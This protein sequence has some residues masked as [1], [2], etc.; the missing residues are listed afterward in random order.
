MRVSCDTCGRVLLIDRS[1]LGRWIRCP[2]CHSLIEVIAPRI[3]EEAAAYTCFTII[4]VVSGVTIFWMSVS[5]IAGVIFGVTFITFA[6]LAVCL[7]SIRHRRE[8]DEFLFRPLEVDSEST[9][10]L[11]RFLDAAGDHAVTSLALFDVLYNLG[12]VDPM[13]LRGVDHLHHGQEFS[14]LNDVSIFL[15]E[16][17]IG[18]DFTV[19]HWERLIHKYK[20]YTGEQYLFDLWRREGIDVEVPES[21]THA[22][23]DATVDGESVNVKVT[24]NPAY[25]RQAL[26]EHPDVTIVTNLEMASHFPDHP[27]VTVKPEMSEH[28]IY[29]RTEASLEGIDD[30]GNLFDNL[31]VLIL[32]AASLRNAKSVQE[33][34]K[35]LLDAAKHIAV[36]TTA[37]GGGGLVGAHLGLM[38][39]TLLTPVTGGASLLIV[40]GTT[41]GGVLSGKLGGRKVAQ[42]VKERRLR[43]L[44]KDLELVSALLFE[45]F[46][47]NHTRLVAVATGP[48]KKLSDELNRHDRLHQGWCGRTFFPSAFTRF[49]YKANLRLRSEIAGQEGYY[50]GLL[51]QPGDQATPG[52]RGMYVFAQG[53]QILLGHPRL[54]EAYRATESLVVDVGKERDRVS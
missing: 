11:N 42:W 19:S 44:L 48:A 31:P 14:N 16:H 33:G 5:A 34:K 39:G 53:E 47:K 49:I 21:G 30:L 40:P 17:I 29:D 10:R 8:V 46:A 54:L 3:R 52:E 6:G 32:A 38:I 2:Q 18:N 41:L 4:V 50:T 20:G 12:K 26:E 37:I 35:S 22:A 28:D 13:F 23:V 24:N 9:A 7:V 45:G 43:K 1:C 15:R 27:R 25:I 51:Q 36:E